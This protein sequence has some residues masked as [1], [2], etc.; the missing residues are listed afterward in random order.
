LTIASRIVTRRALFGAG[1]LA[2]LAG[3]GPQEEPEVDAG[4]VLGEQ[5]RL[6]QAV[7]DAY[8]GVTGEGRAN[9]QRR[10]GRIK[11]ALAG[12]H[13]QPRYTITDGTGSL[14]EA[15]AAEQEALRGH[16]AAVGELKAA[17]YRELLAGLIADAAA[18]EAALLATLDQ[19]PVPS[20]FPGQPV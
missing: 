5:L 4:K 7:V 19:P 20:A 14:Q 13:V 17:P 18:G 16:V 6:T 9:A 12:M 8:S 15:L 1:A 11:A 2:L 3:C 10:V